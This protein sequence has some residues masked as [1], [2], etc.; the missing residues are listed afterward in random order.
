MM[1]FVAIGETDIIYALVAAEPS[2]IVLMNDSMIVIVIV[3]P[4]FKVKP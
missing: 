4:Y 1:G 3:A 2:I